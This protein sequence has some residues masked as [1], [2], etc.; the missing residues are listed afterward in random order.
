MREARAD[1]D[2]ATSQRWRRRLGTWI[3][4]GVVG[5][6][7]MVAA[8]SLFGDSGRIWET[9]K[10]I[11]GEVVVGL[12]GLSL[13]NYFARAARWHVFSGALGLAVPWSRNLLYYMA[14]FAMAVT[15][16]KVGEA[17]RL[18]FLR[19]GHGYGYERTAALVVADRVADAAALVG[20]AAVGLALRGASLVIVM[21]VVGLVVATVLVLAWPAS[22]TWGA[23]IAYRTIGRWP[24]LF[25]RLRIAARQ[26]ARLRSPG[27]L[28]LAMLLSLAG[29]LAEGAQVWWVATELG[30]KIGLWDGAAAFGISAIL[31]A[32]TMSPGGLGGTEVG[33]VAL[34]RDWGVGWEA[35]LTTTVLVRVTTLWFSVAIGLA[36]LPLVLRRIVRAPV[37]ATR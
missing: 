14:G 35:A 25:A 4:I 18:W 31:G 7:A 20:L 27:R 10:S 13:V 21:P 8:L 17:M 5:S 23:G 30:G 33:M 16:G 36:C 34:L 11:R 15:P 32:A 9:V 22:M 3:G 1:V 19:R 37:G 2:F 29:W 12:L 6:I 24:R 26:F 28:G